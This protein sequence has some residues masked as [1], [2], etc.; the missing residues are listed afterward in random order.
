M[1]M[2][3]TASGLQSNAVRGTR[4]AN[5]TFIF[6][7]CQCS[8]RVAMLVPM[9]MLTPFISFTDYGYCRVVFRY[10]RRCYKCFSS[11][12]VHEHIAS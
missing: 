5:K 2:Y 8:S 6:G 3:S 1:C 11:A 9:R 10:D 7:G 4:I 12:G